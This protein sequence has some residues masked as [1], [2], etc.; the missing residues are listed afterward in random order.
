MSDPTPPS[1]AA[2]AA[3]ADRLAHPEPLRR[4]SLSERF[5]KCSKPGCPCASDPDARH[6][7]YLSIAKEMMAAPRGLLEAQGF[8]K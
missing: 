6:G 8:E 4:G 1:A 7:P 2:A 5:V 3:L